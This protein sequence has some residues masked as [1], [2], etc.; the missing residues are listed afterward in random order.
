MSG[1]CVC[2]RASACAYLVRGVVVLLQVGVGQGLL[3]ADALVGVKGQHATQQIQGCWTNQ[4]SGVRGHWT[5]F[6]L[7]SPSTLPLGSLSAPSR[8]P[9]GSSDVLGSV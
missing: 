9:L 1:V 4:Q 2:V 6:I 3:H 7:G 5:E 8:L